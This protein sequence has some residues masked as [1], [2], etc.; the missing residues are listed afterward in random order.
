M[1]TLKTYQQ[2][3]LTV[4]TQFLTDTRSQSVA[5]AY[6]ATLATQNRT[7]ETYQPL[8]GDVPCVC[9]RLPACAHWRRQDHHG[10]ACCGIG[11]QGGVG[12]RCANCPVAHSIRYRSYTNARSVG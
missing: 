3:A 5:D 8:F 7:G 11:R 6:G 10:G 9:L 12:Q 1:L 2:S 4:L